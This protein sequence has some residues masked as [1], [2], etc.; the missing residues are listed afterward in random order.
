MLIKSDRLND[1]D[2]KLWNDLEEIDAHHLETDG[3]QKRKALTI[4]FIKDFIASDKKY[5]C[6]ISWGKDSIVLADMFSRLNADAKFVYFR[7][8]A[9]EP[10]GHQDVKKIFLNT[11]DINYEEVSYD[12]SN[13]DSS[14]FDTKGRPAKWQN[15]LK[16][17]KRKYGCHVTGLRYDESSKRKMRF[18]VFGLETE[19]SF[20]PFRY[21]NVHDIFAYML[22]YN[23]P[24]HPNYAMLGG[25]RWDKYR[26]RVAAIGNKEGNGMGRTEWEKE[27]YQDILNRINKK[28]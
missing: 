3:Y 1:N 12:Y 7:N 22:E 17:Y 6:G 16:E 28:N 8:V 13:Y 2:L 11:H 18:N 20:A 19:Y 21:F 15:L 4:D 5:Y 14:Y 9:R 10:E 27:Y 24:I 25:G 23:L 26:I